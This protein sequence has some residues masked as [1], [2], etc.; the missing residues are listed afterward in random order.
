MT[1]VRSVVR[2]VDMAL[3]LSLVSLALL[4]GCGGKTESATDADASGS[5]SGTTPPDGS[6]AAPVDAETSPDADVTT[7]PTYCSQTQGIVSSCSPEG[8]PPDSGGSV[9][10]C[11]N[12]PGFQCAFLQTRGLWACCAPDSG[13]NCEIGAPCMP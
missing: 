12:W 13:T 10:N 2:L 7:S 8:A 9:E 3:R 6:V 11:L 1:L 4:A 5:E